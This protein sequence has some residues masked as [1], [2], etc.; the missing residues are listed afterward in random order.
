MKRFHFRLEELN[1]SIF[2]FGWRDR[3]A[4]FSIW[5]EGR[6]LADYLSR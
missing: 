5:L 1:G 2:I 3:I 4:P 6:A